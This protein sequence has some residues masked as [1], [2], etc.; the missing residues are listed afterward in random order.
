[1][2]N[3]IYYKDEKC[4]NKRLDFKNCPFYNHEFCIFYKKNEKD[5]EY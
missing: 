1:M 2:K 3:C 4:K 5:I